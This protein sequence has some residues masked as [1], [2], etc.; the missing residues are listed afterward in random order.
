MLCV[1]AQKSNK[2]VKSLEFLEYLQKN[3]VAVA[4]IKKLSAAITIHVLNQI[5]LGKRKRLAVQK[6]G[7]AD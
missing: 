5:N 6:R 4:D 1:F 7:S 2:I 3:L